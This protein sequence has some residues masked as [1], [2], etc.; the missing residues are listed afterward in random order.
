[1][2]EL[3]KKIVIL[4]ILILVIVFSILGCTPKRN[5]M[6]ETTVFKLD[7]KNSSVLDMDL[8]MLLDEDSGIILGKDGIATIRLKVNKK[9]SM[10]VNVALIS[11]IMEDFQI[12][13]I[14][15]D[16]VEE[17]FP[18]LNLAE[19]A[20][21]IGTFD[22]AL[23]VKIKGIDEND[24]VFKQALATLRATGEL[25]SSLVLPEEL[26][27]E[28][29]AEYYIQ[30]VYSQYTG[31][32]TGIYMGKHHPRGE[33]FII[34]DMKKDKDNNILLSYSNDTILLYLLAQQL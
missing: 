16:I 30:D 32:Y 8:S 2:R 7:L 3:N 15:F 22:K 33:P 26:E 13:R 29:S 17:L 6:D 4:C 11:G 24:E 9:L 19:V 10:L 27:V 21:I 25:P 1:M 14:F 12:D 18:G 23:G 5:V 31:R 34:M 20:S 28:I